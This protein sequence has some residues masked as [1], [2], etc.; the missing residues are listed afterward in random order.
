M[1][2]LFVLLAVGVIALPAT[3]QTADFETGDTSSPRVERDE[4]G[5][6]I[7]TARDC[8][9]TLKTVA[10]LGA[11]LERSQPVTTSCTVD[12]KDLIKNSTD[13]CS[14]DVT[15]CV[16]ESVRELHDTFPAHSGPNCFNL[17]LYTAGLN[18]G[19]RFASEEEMT[20][21]MSSP[22]CHKL[23]TSEKPQPGD[24]GAIRT[25]PVNGM[26]EIHG[27]VYITEDLVYSKNTIDKGTSYS[28]QPTEDVYRYYP[29]GPA[30]KC[31][32]AYPYFLEDCAHKVDYFRCGSLDD[33][34]KSQPEL[35]S[36]SRPM[37]DRFAAFERRLEDFSVD[38]V[39]VTAEDRELLVELPSLIET[40][41]S[42]RSEI[43]F[44][45]EDYHELIVVRM[46]ATRI[47]SALQQL[48]MIVP[49]TKKDPN[50]EELK[51]LLTTA[52]AKLFR[53]N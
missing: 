47:T 15:A 11:W 23:G 4:S 10:A 33:Y 28:L 26:Y 39:T 29:V 52:R 3:A 1:K 31:K 53:E 2:A 12:E 18:G 51:A 40:F 30:R 9:E 46:M 5:R 48:N 45:N 49:Y 37:L 17:A 19:L 27:F 42:R 35:A 21:Y 43:E 22:F 8:K 6:L 41:H 36:I 7:L 44:E 50:I 13:S 20:L 24:I 32:G 14:Y 38:G 16:P 25:H 34:W